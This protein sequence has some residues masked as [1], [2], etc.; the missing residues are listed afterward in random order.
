MGD[1][2]YNL[3]DQVINAENMNKHFCEVGP[4]LG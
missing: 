1:F 4:L 2:N 3:D